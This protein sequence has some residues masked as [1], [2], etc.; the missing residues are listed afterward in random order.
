MFYGICDRCHEFRLCLNVVYKI[1]PLTPPETE[2]VIGP[3]YIRER[4]VIN[5]EDLAPKYAAMCGECRAL[6][7]LADR[8]AKVRT[9]GLPWT[10]DAA[11]ALALD[12]MRLMEA[13]CVTCDSLPVKY[14]PSEEWNARHRGHSISFGGVLEAGPYSVRYK[15]DGF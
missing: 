12:N 9:R 2:F 1:P 11:I 3:D 13:W 15:I 5:R 4:P 10:H 7:D 14:P 8:R 6:N